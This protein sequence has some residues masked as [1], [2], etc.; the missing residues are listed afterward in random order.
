MCLHTAIEINFSQPF[1]TVDENSGIIQI[2]LMF[3]NPSSIDIT[4]EVNSEDINAT[5]EFT[6]HIYSYAIVC[7]SV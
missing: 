4:V 6:V 3:S 7:I 2:Q 1:Y 5:G